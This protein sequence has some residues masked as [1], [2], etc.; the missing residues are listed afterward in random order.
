MKKMDDKEL[1]ILLSQYIDGTLS[2]KEAQ[3]L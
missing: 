2:A 3:K 1:D